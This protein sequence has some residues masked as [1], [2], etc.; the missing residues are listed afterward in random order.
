MPIEIIFLWDFDGHVEK[1]ADSFEGV[2]Q[3]MISGK[4]IWKEKDCWSFVM[5]KSMANMRFY[6]EKN[7][8]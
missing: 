7:N 1:R 4:E 8:H 3:E 5:E 6:K 2:H